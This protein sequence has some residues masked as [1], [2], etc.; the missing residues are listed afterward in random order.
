MTCSGPFVREHDKVFTGGK[1]KEGK[2]Q[3]VM[4]RH[5]D[6]RM[7]GGYRQASL[8]SM[9]ILVKAAITG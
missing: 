5:E 3:G 6:V 1:K 2:G 8:V 4:E 9:L 7:E